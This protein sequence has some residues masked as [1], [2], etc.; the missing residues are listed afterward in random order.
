MLGYTKEGIVA[1]AQGE[2]FVVIYNKYWFLHKIIVN[3]LN[4]H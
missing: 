3:R 4:D 1:K 2:I